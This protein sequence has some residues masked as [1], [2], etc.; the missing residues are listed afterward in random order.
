MQ[1]SHA[2]LDVH[3]LHPYL[4]LLQQGAGLVASYVYANGEDPI[5]TGAIA[6]SGTVGTGPGGD[7]ESGN[8][9]FTQLA[10]IAGCGGDL[11]AEEELACMQE[12]PAVRLQAILQSGREDVPMFGAVVDNITIFS[13]YTERLER[14]LVA[15][16]V[17]F[18]PVDEKRSRCAF[19]GTS[20]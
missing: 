14:G 7:D 3:S 10:E 6:S 13:N 16:V 15:N 20:Y 5:I 18:F 17:S 9:K 1:V 11:E 2:R 12:I 4:L 19:E 8:N